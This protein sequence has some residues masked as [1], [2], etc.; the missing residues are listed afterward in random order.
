MAA[1][2]SVVSIDKGGKQEPMMYFARNVANADPVLDGSGAGL[3]KAYKGAG[4]VAGLM[5]Q[6]L[7][8]NHVAFQNA[9]QTANRVKQVYYYMTEGVAGEPSAS[10]ITPDEIAKAGTDY[11]GWT[12]GTH[13]MNRSSDYHTMLYR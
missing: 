2:E 10:Y 3:T 6:G 13:E 12:H 9:V 11:S 8:P 5:D 7:D 1:L 4:V